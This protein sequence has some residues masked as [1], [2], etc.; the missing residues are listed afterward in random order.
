MCRFNIKYINVFGRVENFANTR[1]ARK[2]TD[3]SSIFKG[4]SLSFSFKSLNKL[5][6]RNSISTIF[7][8]YFRA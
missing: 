3:K 8:Y 6:S 4:L 2:H 5:I 1:L 7:G